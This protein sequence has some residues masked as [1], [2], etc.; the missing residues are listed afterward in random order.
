MTT[1]RPLI[2][3]L[4]LALAAVLAFN[5][6]RPS[7]AQGKAEPVKTWEYMVTHSK[8][9]SAVFDPLGQDGWEMCGCSSGVTP[10]G[11]T[12]YTFVFKRPKR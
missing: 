8:P 7:A 1:F 9:S 3:A 11:L 12:L 4:G 2:V 6:G 10:T 5:S